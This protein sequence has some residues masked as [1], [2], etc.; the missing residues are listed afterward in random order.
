M[1][2][3]L[4]IWSPC[5]QIASST[6]SSTP[7]LEWSS[8]N[9]QL[10]ISHPFTSRQ[11]KEKEAALISA[12]APTHVLAALSDPSG[13]GQRAPWLLPRIHEC[14]GLHSALFLGMTFMKPPGDCVL[15]LGIKRCNSQ[16][17][18]VSLVSWS[19]GPFVAAFASSSSIMERQESSAPE[20]DWGQKGYHYGWVSGWNTEKPIKFSHCKDES[21]DGISLVPYYANT[22]FVYF[23]VLKIFSFRLFVEERRLV[24]CGEKKKLKKKTSLVKK[25]CTE[26]KTL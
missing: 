24:S 1:W 21:P 26:F 4:P 9:A 18:R 13:A 25:S 11:E 2:L 6:P 20:E 23:L 12:Q 8:Q 5:P 7:P 3:P 10:N 15:Y 14:T 17:P 22:V 19:V 16:S